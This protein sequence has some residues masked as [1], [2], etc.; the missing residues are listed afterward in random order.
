MKKLI[1]PI[2]F[3]AFSINSIAQNN[4]Q[5]EETTVNE[6]FAKKVALEKDGKFKDRFTIQ[7]IYGGREVATKTKAKYDNLN[8]SWPSE[9]KWESPNHKVWIGKFRNR[10]EADRALIEIREHFPDAF[11]LKP[12]S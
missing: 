2:V 7:L 1:L 3:I 6:L 9:L 12:Q 4:T 5:V 10:L 11:I 8:L